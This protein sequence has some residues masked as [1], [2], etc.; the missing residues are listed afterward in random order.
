MADTGK[1]EV[2]LPMLVLNGPLDD[3]C[4][5]ENTNIFTHNQSNGEYDKLKCDWVDFLY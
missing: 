5:K 2:Q 4:E 1:T 3:L